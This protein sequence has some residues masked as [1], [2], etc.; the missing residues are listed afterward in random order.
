M[1]AA[2]NLVRNTIHLVTSPLAF[3]LGVT[4]YLLTGK[5]PNFGRK[6]MR[7]LFVFT[8]GRLNDWSGKLSNRLHP[9]YENIK[10]NGVLGKL[11]ATEIDTIVQHIERDGFYKFSA[12]LPTEVI[13]NIRNFALNTPARYLK[14]DKATGINYSS[15]L[16]KFDPDNIISPRYQF[17]KKQLVQQPNIQQLMFDSSI[18]AVAQRYLAAQPV[19]DKVIMWWSAPFGGKGKSGAAQMYHFDMDR[20]KFLKFFFYLTDVDLETGPHCYVRGSHKRLPR[21]LQSDGRKTDAEV[22]QCFDS[23]DFLEICGKAGTIL[24][25]DTRGLHKGKPLT[26]DNRL[27]FQLEFANSMF[28][29]PYETV[30]NIELS[31]THQQTIKQF[32]YTYSSVIKTNH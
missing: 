6:A 16:V 28:G 2:I 13:H 21:K 22:A 24:A 26:K 15:E 11:S 25:V 3:L 31:A 5:T 17:K 19:L 18:L 14:T 23:S 29:A 1:K 32:P 4:Q 8:N 30:E 10:A 9:P 7:R 12:R 20:L 27:I